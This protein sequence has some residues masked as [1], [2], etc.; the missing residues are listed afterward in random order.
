MFKEMIL[1]LGVVFIAFSAFGCAEVQVWERGNLAKPHMAFDPDPLEKR[2][3][4]HV[5]ESKT[6]SSGGYGVGGG[7]C[8]C[9]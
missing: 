8:G 6:A 2:F 9:N 4:Q 1:I 7:G 5:H 3:M